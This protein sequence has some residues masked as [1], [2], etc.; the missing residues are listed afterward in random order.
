MFFRLV[1]YVTLKHIIQFGFD[2]KIS[3]LPHVGFRCSDLLADF[4]IATWTMCIGHL[5]LPLN[6]YADIWPV[7]IF[8]L[9]LMG[10]SDIFI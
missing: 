6:Y 8:W 4:V 1:V 10:R 3:L 5:H 7:R 9:L 2:L